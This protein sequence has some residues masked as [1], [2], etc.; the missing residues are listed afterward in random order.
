MG[1]LIFGGAYALWRIELLSNYLAANRR[2]VLE[3]DAAWQKHID[4]QA[5]L[6]RE[7]LRRLPAR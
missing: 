6:S 1:L 5:E 4:A 2:Y 7:I 3:R